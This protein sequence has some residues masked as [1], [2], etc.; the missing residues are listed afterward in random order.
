MEMSKEVLGRDLKLVDDLLDKELGSDLAINSSGD[1][2]TVSEE[3]N[4]GQAIV[5]RIRTTQ[6]ELR[7][8]GHSLYGSRLYELVGEPNN[9]RTRELAR[10]YT[11]ESVSRDP[12]VK[13]IISITVNVSKDDPN[14]IDLN[15]S[16]LPIGMTT[17]LNI[18][19]P[20][21]LEVA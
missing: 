20:F 5:N 3:F 8:L 18:V 4:L 7:D 13:E 14:R 11:R 2:E 9:Q 19:F 6:G 12:R 1:L 17:V 10:L 16:V 21:Y 15:I